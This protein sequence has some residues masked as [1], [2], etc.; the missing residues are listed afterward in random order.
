MLGIFQGTD[1]DAGVDQQGFFFPDHQVLLES[2]RAATAIAMLVFYFTV[3]R[4][5]FDVG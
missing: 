4:R 5:K 1:A 2:C 3:I